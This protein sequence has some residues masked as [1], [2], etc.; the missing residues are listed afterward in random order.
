[1][2]YTFV[3]PIC[4]RALL[5]PAFYPQ[6]AI[7]HSPDHS[8]LLRSLEIL[9]FAFWIISWAYSVDLRKMQVLPCAV[10]DKGTSQNGDEER[11][12]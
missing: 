3:Q 1:M 4:C 2:I 10:R 7:I 5:T 9:D 8:H 6:F 11:E 12:I